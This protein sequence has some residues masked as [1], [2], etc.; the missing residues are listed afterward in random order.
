MLYKDLFIFIVVYISVEQKLSY[1]LNNPYYLYTIH[2]FL[3]IMWLDRSFLITPVK[4]LS[5]A[6]A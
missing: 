3:A 2:S 1:Y 5:C 4:F 6:H